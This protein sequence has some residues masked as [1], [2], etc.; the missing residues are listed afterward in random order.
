MLMITPPPACGHG[1]IPKGL[2]TQQVA[3]QGNITTNALSATGSCMIV[4]AL[5]MIFY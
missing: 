5:S 2:L 3:P 1:N 4:S